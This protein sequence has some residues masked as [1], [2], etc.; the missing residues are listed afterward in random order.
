MLGLLVPFRALLPFH[1][2][3][4]FPIVTCSQLDNS[5]VNLRASPVLLFPSFLHIFFFLSVVFI[6]ELFYG[7]THTLLTLHRFN[8][9]KICAFAL[10]VCIV[11][12]RQVYYVRITYYTLLRY[13]TTIQEFFY[14]WLPYHTIS[15]ILPFGALKASPGFQAVTSCNNLSL[16]VKSLSSIARLRKPWGIFFFAVLNPVLF[17]FLFPDCYPLLFFDA[18]ISFEIMHWL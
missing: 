4:R 2:N 7:A 13:S 16:A 17:Y 1:F 3:S 15:L 9:C 11:P 5:L 10:L 8:M 12:M 6:M 14:G 18:V